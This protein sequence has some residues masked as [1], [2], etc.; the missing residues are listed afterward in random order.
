MPF[1]YK[2]PDPHSADADGLLAAGGDLTVESLITAYSKGIFPWYNEGSPI[3][4][5]SPDPRLI[6]YPGNFKISASLKQ[7]IRK[8]TFRVTIDT[9]FERVIRQCALIKRH[10]QNG[11]WL[12]GEM[13]LAYIALH[14]AGL[15]HSFEV[16][17][18]GN[19]AGGLYG[20]SLGRAFF[21]ESMFHTM[22]NASKI[23]LYTLARWTA[24][25]EFLF[26]DAQQSTE[27]LKSL[28][29]K[30]IPRKEFLT[31]LQ[32]AL[33]YPTLRGNWKM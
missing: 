17:N 4:W 30:E 10:G 8:Q 26:I 3:L 5:W 19:L 23:A 7:T 11:T 14:D 21:G 33:Q 2:F 16:W 31:L 25:R 18:N 29:A 22:S 32:Q 24:E 12:T 27:H 13:I 20:I 15:A 28:G 6:L 1:E 9:Q